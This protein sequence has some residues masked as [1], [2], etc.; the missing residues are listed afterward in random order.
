MTSISR[1]L[2]IACV[3]VVVLAVPGFASAKAPAQ[4]RSA[5][6]SSS[7][8]VEKGVRYEPGRTYTYQWDSTVLSTT[9]SEGEQGAGESRGHQEFHALVGI[10]AVEDRGDGSYLLE[11]TVHDPQA[12][13]LDETGALVPAQDREVL[14][15]LQRPI[16]FEQLPNGQIGRV[17]INPEESKAAVNIKRSI[18]SSLQV[19][20]APTGEL[21]RDVSG[22][23]LP[24]YEQYE[25]GPQ[26][27]FQRARTQNDYLQL[28]DPAR[29]KG[30]F[31]SDDFSRTVFDREQGVVTSVETKGFLRAARSERYGDE[32]YSIA[33]TADVMG[34]LRFLGTEVLPPSEEKP[35]LEYYVDTDLVAEPTEDETF[36]NE[37]P[38]EE[39][40]KEDL[41]VLQQSPNDPAR[42]NRLVET[43]RR[44]RGTVA[45][46]GTALQKGAVAPEILDAVSGALAAVGTPEAQQLLIQQLRVGGETANQA[47]MSLA[48]VTRPTVE[49]V[50]AVEQLAAR[51][52]SPLY[53]QA[54]LVLGALAQRL[55]GTEP[56]RARNIAQRL[57][58][59]LSSTSDV[60][61]LELYLNAL[62]NAGTAA[63]LRSLTPYLSHPS[64]EVRL[65]TVDALRKQPARQVEGQLRALA[66]LERDPMLRDIARETLEELTGGSGDMGIY[67]VYNRTWDKWF[68]GRDL[69]AQ[70]T[71]EL[72]IDSA[73]DIYLRSQGDAYAWAFNRSY[74]IVRA[75]ALSEVVNQ[76]GTLKRRFNGFVSVVGITLVNYDEY[77]TCGAS[78][79]G[80]LL[81]TST[82]GLPATRPSAWR[83]R[84][85]SPPPPG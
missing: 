25:E 3:A 27:V 48:F 54:T 17:L 76:N 1:R 51:P 38:S 58:R 75:R 40:L 7:Y 42:F 18:I 66:I 71:A 41:T 67:T 14:M 56:L 6:L 45:L 82:C 46:L 57:V 52:S 20:L 85:R 61:Q 39:Q 43:L 62:G 29:E 64:A 47:L 11:A 22:H 19:P 31:A 44:S 5:G 9:S 24:R 80:N 68:G 59:E 33:N 50:A 37:P 81:S 35:Q 70:L 63:E 83:P 15:Q 8:Y 77:L 69:G 65:A 10:R 2:L 26:L 34:S 55:Q 60:E 49:A 72:Y 73:N 78:K 74:N 4:T 23:Y 30:D 79:T 32:G 13:Y 16:Y 36:G 84:P 12:L 28:A 21:E 53:R